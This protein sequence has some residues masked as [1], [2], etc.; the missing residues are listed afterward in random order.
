MPW[1]GL[2][3][4]HGSLRNGTIHGY[5]DDSRVAARE[6]P[7]P[8][9]AGVREERFPSQLDALLSHPEHADLV[10]WMPHGRVWRVVDPAQFSLPRGRTSLR[11]GKGTGK[12][13]GRRRPR[14]GCL[15]DVVLRRRSTHLPGIMMYRRKRRCVGVVLPCL[16]CP[17]SALKTL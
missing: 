14:V 8:D 7:G 2:A 6:L 3:R 12:V 16:P 11:A 17:G 10:R 5:R 9:D 1:R 4:D 15:R 13:T